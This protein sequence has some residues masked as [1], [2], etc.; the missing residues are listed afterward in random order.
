[1]HKHRLNAI[2]QRNRARVAC[3]ARTAQFQL[4]NTILKPAELNVAAVFLNR[5]PDARFQ[6]FLDHANDLV[7]VFIVTKGILVASFLRAAVTARRPLHRVH[8]RLSGRHDFGD[9]AEDFRLD[10]RPVRVAG[11]GHR[12]E[13][14]SEEHRRHAV[15]IEQVGGQRRRVRRRQSRSWRQILEERRGEILWQDGL[16]GKKLESLFIETQCQYSFVF[17][18]SISPSVVPL[19]SGFGVD[20]V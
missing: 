18:C 14:R 12:D 4:H 17:L 11:L 10:V 1:M 5:R 9:Q 20:S 13:V 19:T 16:I 8:D 2:L 15:N 7:V 3:T 6:Q